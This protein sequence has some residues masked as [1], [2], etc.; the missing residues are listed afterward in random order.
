MDLK[1][2]TRRE[3]IPLAIV[4]AAAPIIAGVAPLRR[5]HRFTT[6]GKVTQILRVSDGVQCLDAN[7][8]LVFRCIFHSTGHQFIY[9]P[10]NTTWSMPARPQQGTFVPVGAPPDAVVTIAAPNGGY[11]NVSTSYGQTSGQLQLSAPIQTQVPSK[12]QGWQQDGNMPAQLQYGPK[13][14]THQPCPQIDPAQC[15][16]DVF[17]LIAASIAVAVYMVLVLAGGEFDP[18]LIALLIAAIAYW[19]AAEMQAQK[20]CGGWVY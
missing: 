19:L 16:I 10:S 6:Y 18:A 15:L 12:W 11:G 4:G 7:N 3:M 9:Y 20:D 17:N 14:C 2:F 13:P 5:A 8:N 1:K